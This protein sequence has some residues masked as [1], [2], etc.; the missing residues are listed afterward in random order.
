MEAQCA[1]RDCSCHKEGRISPCRGKELKALAFWDVFVGSYEEG[2]VF[3]IVCFLNY[4]GYLALNC[5]PHFDS[6]GWCDERNN[7]VVCGAD[8]VDCMYNFGDQGDANSN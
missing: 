1:C 2:I 6:D 3:L 7:N 4:A 8:G 5:M